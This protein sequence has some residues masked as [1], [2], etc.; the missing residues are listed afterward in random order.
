[1]RLFRRVKYLFHRKRREQELEEELAFHRALA[2]QEQRDAG[3]A[4]EMARR[5]ASR[6]MGNTTLA[7]EAAHYVWFPAAI[8]GILQD[9]RYAWRGLSHSKALLSVACLSLGL[10]TGFGTALFSIVNAVILQPVTASRPDAL[11]RLWVGNGNRISWLNLRDICEPAQGVACAG[12]NIEELAWDRGGEPMRLFGQ[13]VSPHY[14]TMLGIDVAQGRVFTA[15]TVRGT[16]DAVVLT[17]AF[18]KR[19]LGSD[20][21]IIG[22]RLVLTGHPYTV[23]GILPRTFRS[24]WGFGI[25]PSLYL[26]IGS[27]VRPFT[28]K[29]AATDYEILGVLAPGQSL[30]ELHS[31][32]L[33][34]A[35]ALEGA[36]PAENREFGRVQIFP[37]HRLGLFLR[38]DDPMMRALLLFASLLVVFVLLLAVVACVNVAGLLVARAMARQREIAIRLSIG[39]GQ[40]RLARLL[41]AESFLLAIAGVGIGAVLSFW[42]ARLLVAVPLPFPVPFELEVPI[43]THVLAYLA[44]LVGLA[45]LVAGVAPVLEAW[46]VA[47]VGAT[48]TAPRA[49]GFRRWSMRRV[50]IAGQVAV[51]TVLLVGTTL[52]VR[53]LWAASRIDPGFDIDRVVTVEVETR[54]GQLKEAE[55][56]AYYRAALDRLRNLPGVTAVSGAIVVPLSM[57]S[58]VNSVLVNR[59]DKEQAV[60]VNTNSILPGYFRVMGIPLRAGR[61]F[62]EGDRQTKLRAAIVNETFARRLFPGRSA[63]GQRVRRPSS[64]ESPEPWAEIVAVVA[65]SRYLTLG[66]ETRPQVYWPMEPNAGNMTIHV[67]TEGDAAALARILPGILSTVDSRVPA[68]VRPLRSVMAV[69]LFPAQAAAVLFAALGLVGWALTVA[70]LYGVVAYTVARRVPE[71]GVRL[72]LGAPPSRVMLLLL[73]D[74]LAITFVGLTVGLVLAALAMPVLAS[75]LAGV[76]PHDITSFALVAAVLVVTAVAA[77]YGPARRGM[78][79]SPMD[80]LRNE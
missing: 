29:R 68:R 80:A 13:A 59:G 38:N 56:A 24:I 37:I 39:C 35:K 62:G 75:F 41:L 8:E 7:R 55:V 47:V 31:R 6:Q 72:A 76:Q 27:A 2:E 19:Q 70:G 46:R 77:S 64:T 69:A 54:S 74:G 33:A 21:N 60:T 50:L 61:E 40:M 9:V 71:I 43:D 36:Y 63:I 49:A 11:V 66:E 30:G 3:L 58:I 26:P 17:H 12:Y 22:R 48:G 78:R 20:P 51:S 23:I 1:M 65:D 53:S 10:G 32:V 79:L 57:N 44:A 14:F 5:A 52:F 16:P 73:R 25:A 4:P 45:T 18:W 15:E 28:N 42:L 34:R 67:R